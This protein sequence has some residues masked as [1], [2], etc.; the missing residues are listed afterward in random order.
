MRRIVSLL[1][2][3]LILIPLWAQQPEK[4]SLQFDQLPL[5]KVLQILSQKFNVRYSY[6]DTHVAAENIT[7]ISLDYT[8]QQVHDAIQ[9]QTNL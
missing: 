2:F 5:E 4:H 9:K 1:Y 6:L 3:F 8:L 7:L